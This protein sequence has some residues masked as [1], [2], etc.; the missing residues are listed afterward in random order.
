MDYCREKNEFK[1]FLS[2]NLWGLPAPP[3]PPRELHKLYFGCT[4]QEILET[5]CT[6][7]IC[8][9]SL[10]D[11]LQATF[12]H[13]AIKRGSPYSSSCLHR[14]RGLGYSQA[15]KESQFSLVQFPLRCQ[16][17]AGHLKTRY[18]PLWHRFF[19][20]QQREIFK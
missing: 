4:C 16:P 9:A 14:Q 1:D 10:S 19:S 20:L 6:S 3:Q 5:P 18:P 15:R 2:L 7:T 13:S 12:L 11:S 8:V 17:T